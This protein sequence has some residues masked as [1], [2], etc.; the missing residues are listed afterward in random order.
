MGR[1]GRKNKP[2]G[3]KKLEG[4]PGK[5]P[6][7]EK[8]PQPRILD[9]VPPCPDHLTSDARIEW[10]R[11]AEELSYCHILSRLELSLLEAYCESIGRLKL[12]TAAFKKCDLDKLDDTDAK[13]KVRVLVSVIREA[14]SQAKAIAA[15]LGITPSSR[16]RLTDGSLLG[17]GA[18]SGVTTAGATDAGVSKSGN[19]DL[20]DTQ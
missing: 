7:N 14:S 4:N 6:L 12:A 2:T 13:Q 19:Q 11:C 17:S 16:T 15:E 10:D 20:F 3:R 18:G 8:E 1:G 5:R 9:G